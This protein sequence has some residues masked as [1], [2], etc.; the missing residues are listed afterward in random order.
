MIFKVTAS[1]YMYTMGVPKFFVWV[2][3]I[4][5]LFVKPLNKIPVPESGV[6][7]DTLLI[8]MNGLFHPAMQKVFKYGAHKPPQRFMK[9]NVSHIRQPTFKDLQKKAHT[10]VCQQIETLLR[11]VRPM[12]TLV[13]CVDGPAP[14]AKECQQRQRRFRSASEQDDSSIFDSCNLSPGTQFMDNLTKYIDWYI[15]KQLTESADWRHLEVIFSN[16]KVPGEG[17]YKAMNYVRRFGKDEETF[18]LHGNDADLLMLA[19]GT[20]RP[21]FYVLRDDMYDTMNDYYLV[22]V[23]GISVELI[24]MLKWSNPK[25][26]FNPNM[27]ITDFI[28]MCFMVGND[29]LPH[30]PSLEIMRGGI[31]SMITIYKTS[32]ETKGHLCKKTSHGLRFNIPCLEVFLETLATKEKEMV[33]EKLNCGESYFEDKLLNANVNQQTMVMDGRVSTYSHVNI[34]SYRENYVDS[35]IGKDNI[36]QVCHLYLEGLNWVL[37][38]YTRDVPIWT[39]SFNYHYAPFAFHLVKYLKTFKEVKMYEPTTA[40]LQYYQLM[41]ILPPSSSN[42]LPEPLASLL[43]SCESPLAHLCP[44]E[45][46]IDFSGKKA[47]WEGITI[48]PFMDQTLLT[49][50]YK[51]FIK[52]VPDALQKRNKHGTSFRYIFD[53][54][55]VSTFKSYYGDIECAVKTIPINLSSMGYT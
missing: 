24:E 18:C 44:T 20:N 52:K 48:V 40:P 47:E 6:H 31:D 50:I 25:I 28:F 16:E 2:K 54:M 46:S 4:F 5:P 30:I 1:M 53:P 45:V 8:D 37:D 43:S 32:A 10:E 29:F 13:L 3:N 39:W 7:V 33:E 42:L 23:S 14:R 22:N 21:N 26:T 12:K 35:L 41:N 34:E 15:R 36:E 51:T 38:Y 9:H 19:L 17:E 11:V 55:A 49:S 27:A